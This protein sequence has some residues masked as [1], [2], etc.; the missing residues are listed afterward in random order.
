MS[1]S[2]KSFFKRKKKKASNPL[3]ITVVEETPVKLK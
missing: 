1:G 2:R 3:D